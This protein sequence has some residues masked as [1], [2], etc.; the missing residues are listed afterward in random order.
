MGANEAIGVIGTGDKSQRAEQVDYKDYLKQYAENQQQTRRPNSI[1]VEGG[2]F[3][4]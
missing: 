1:W 2:A 4:T 3:I